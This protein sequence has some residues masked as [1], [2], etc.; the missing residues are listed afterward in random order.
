[1]KLQTFSQKSGNKR[2]KYDFCLVLPNAMDLFSNITTT[3]C[4]K[5]SMTKFDILIIIK[6]EV[7]WKSAIKSWKYLNLKFE[8]LIVKS[9][10]L[11]KHDGCDKQEL[12]ATLR[13]TDTTVICGKSRLEKGTIPK[14]QQRR[15]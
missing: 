4:T 2:H 5:E 1:M 14:Y 8:I 7:L 11:I 12:V 13:T 3:V 6:S 15:K 10:C 9:V